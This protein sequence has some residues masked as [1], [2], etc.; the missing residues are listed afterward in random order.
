MYYKFPTD[1]HI[2]ISFEF[3]T[4]EQWI[5]IGVFFYDWTRVTFKDIVNTIIQ[6]VGLCKESSL[7]EK[8]NDNID[9]CD[10]EEVFILFF[11][12]ENSKFISTSLHV[13]YIKCTYCNDSSPSLSIEWQC[14]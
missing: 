10:I 4:I 1:F 2:K 3:P 8:P 7:V 9:F 13:K 11:Y 12:I 5:N 6:F 14:Q